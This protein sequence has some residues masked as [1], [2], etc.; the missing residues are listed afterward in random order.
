LPPSK[1]FARLYVLL[2]RR[3][4]VGVVFR[5]GPSGKVLLIKWNLKQDTFEA[6]QWLKG[7]IYERRGDLS[8]DG[9]LLIYL[10][11]KYNLPLRTWTAISKPPY[12]KAL[13]LWKNSGTWGGGGLFES[14][15]QI[16]LNH[17]SYRMVLEEGFSLPK[18]MSVQP[19]GEHSGSGEDDPIWSTRLARDGWKLTQWSQQTKD[20]R[21]A[22]VWIEYDPPIVWEKPHPYWPKKYV[23]KMS[24]LGIS[25]KDGPWHVID[26]DLIGPDGNIGSIGRS[27]WADWAPNGDLLFSQS[28][29][30]YRLSPEKQRFGPIESSRIIGDFNSLSFEPIVAPAESSVWPRNRKRRN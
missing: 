15:K 14:S 23:L 30:L 10:A 26:H 2:A 9:D 28:G 7:R 3:A 21:E 27:E 24:R 19:L 18:S 20:D 4:P 25:E 11:A 1:S 8:P 22:K 17:R 6:G 5:R 16:Q 13:A 12:L 29:C